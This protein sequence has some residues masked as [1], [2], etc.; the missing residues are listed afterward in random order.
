M[1]RRYSKIIPNQGRLNEC[2]KSSCDAMYM[3]KFSTVDA[4]ISKIRGT[5]TMN[6]EK[7]SK[8]I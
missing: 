8:N 3:E 6:P 5:E 7:L 4:V 2:K 1:L